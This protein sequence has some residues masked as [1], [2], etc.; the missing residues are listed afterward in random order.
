MKVSVGNTRWLTKRRIQVIFSILIIFFLY[1]GYSNYLSAP[2]EVDPKLCDAAALNS[3]VSNWEKLVESGMFYVW[4]SENPPDGHHSLKYRC[5]LYESYQSPNTYFVID[6]YPNDQSSEI[7]IESSEAYYTR[8]GLSDQLYGLGTFGECTITYTLDSSH[9][10]ILGKFY[11]SDASPEIINSMMR[12]I[13][14]VI[15]E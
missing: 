15:S 10:S 3:I 8:K 4:H 1:Q 14:R 12:E 7:C 6:I 9:C 5:N 13:L 11:D 2:I